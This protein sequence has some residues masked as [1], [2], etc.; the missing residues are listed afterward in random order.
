MHPDASLQWFLLKA[1]EI[2]LPAPLKWGIA[3]RQGDPSAMPFLGATAA[4]ASTFTLEHPHIA[5]L[6][7]AVDKIRLE[8]AQG[9]RDLPPQQLFVA[10]EGSSETSLASQFGGVDLQDAY[11]AEASLT[12]GFPAAPHVHHPARMGSAP[13]TSAVFIACMSGDV[14]EVR[15]YLE[16]G[17][18]VDATYKELYGWDV[19][20]EWRFTQ[21]SQDVTLLNYVAT[22][23]DVIG[24][25]APE[26]VQLLLEHGADPRRDDGLE[27]WYLPLHNAVA[28]GA[29][30]VV[31]ILLHM[32]PDLVNETTGDG[33]SSLHLL[34]LCDDAQDRMITLELLIKV[35]RLLEATSSRIHARFLPSRHELVDKPKQRGASR[36]DLL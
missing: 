5:Q 16:Q 10:P 12:G 26:L 27:K 7:I 32:H 33:E 13:I 8:H 28:N 11:L 18:H 6:R 17:G 20:P 34:R 35:C 4:D 36:S 31:R 2:P 3:H 19:G 21:P 30:D 25:P 22:W 29:H 23:T 9:G 15:A 1:L 14:D 24:A